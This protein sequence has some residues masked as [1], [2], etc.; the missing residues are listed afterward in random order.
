MAQDAILNCISEPYLI[1]YISTKIRY[2]WKYVDVMKRKLK[3]GIAE[4]HE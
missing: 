4:G 1:L 2:S 3:T